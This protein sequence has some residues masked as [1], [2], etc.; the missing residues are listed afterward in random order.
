MKAQQERRGAQ[1]RRSCGGF[2]AW[3]LFAGLVLMLGL[4][5]NHWADNE[6]RSKA[7]RWL[8][9]YSDTLRDLTTMMEKAKDNPGLAASG[10]L[11]Q[12]LVE[13]ITNL[14]I[15]RNQIRDNL[16]PRAYSSFHHKL[17]GLGAGLQGYLL[18]VA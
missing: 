1:A 5:Y 6:Y 8:A 15:T 18:I 7:N 12:Q 14:S 9:F 16:P 3:G 4:S 2:L 17:R 11:R 10:G 13:M